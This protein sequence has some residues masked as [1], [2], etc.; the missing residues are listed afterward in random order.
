VKRALTFQFF[1]IWEDCDS[2]SSSYFIPL[3]NHL[4]FSGS[5]WFLCDVAGTAFGVTDVLDFDWLF[6][7]SREQ[8]AECPC[9]CPLLCFSPGQLN[10]PGWLLA[11]RCGAA[12][13]KSWVASHLGLKYRV[14]G[15]ITKKICALDVVLLR[16]NK[17]VSRVQKNEIICVV[18]SLLA[19][20]RCLTL[21]VSD[22]GA[23]VQQPKS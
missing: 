8:S 14:G 3:M 22:F 10:L 13:E 16:G 11:Q 5:K 20:I 2:V 15:G 18:V 9:L 17:A 4:V 1:L 6:N 12:R 7:T 21:W 23:A 19:A